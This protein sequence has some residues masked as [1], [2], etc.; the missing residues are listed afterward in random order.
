VGVQARNPCQPYQIA[1]R[2]QITE[3]RRHL[4]AAGQH[5]L[6]VENEFTGMRLDPQ[7]MAELKRVNAQQAKEIEKLKHQLDAQ[8]TELLKAKM[9]ISVSEQNTRMEKA[10][11]E[12]ESKRRG[13]VEARLNKLLD[14]HKKMTA[15]FS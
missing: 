9:D 13:E 12:E 7:E 8:T 10:A 1:D 3:L 2:L 6:A 5:L 14:A 11:R 4:E 15:M